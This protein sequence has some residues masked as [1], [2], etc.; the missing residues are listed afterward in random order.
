MKKFIIAALFL[1]CLGYHFYKIE[2]AQKN[3]AS[4][5]FHSLRRM[6][7]E[8]TPDVPDENDDMIYL[9]PSKYSRRKAI[10]DCETVVYEKYRLWE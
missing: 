2:Q 8:V 9:S 1:F 10:M 7:L 4:F 6:E 5:I 3:T